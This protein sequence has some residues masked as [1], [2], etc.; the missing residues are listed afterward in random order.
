MKQA[1]GAAMVLL[2]WPVLVEAGD[3]CRVD[4]LKVTFVGSDG[5]MGS[6]YTVIKFKN[7]SKVG[8]ELES[9][10]VFERSSAM[11]GYDADQPR[12]W[13]EQKSCG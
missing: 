5:A 11:R 9:N 10:F 13:F 1:V 3:R 12:K 8:C 4:Q 2:I 7:V 6:Y